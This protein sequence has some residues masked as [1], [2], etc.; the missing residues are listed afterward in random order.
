MPHRV[1]VGQRELPLEP[2]DP[3]RPGSGLLRKCDG[4]LDR[5]RIDAARRD[6]GERGSVEA[7]RY[8]EVLRAVDVAIELTEL[9]AQLVALRLTGVGVLLDRVD[10]AVQPVDDGPV[11][12][13]RAH[14]DAEGEREKDRDERH[15]V[16]PEV[17][18]AIRTC[19][20]SRTRSRAG[21]ARS[22]AGRREWAPTRC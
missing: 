1:G 2:E 8:R 15:D 16:E 20:R 18:H 17:D 12:D 19:R 4:L 11:H 21:S 5:V 7:S 9:T 3:R 6:R 10:P 14:H 13:G 22:P